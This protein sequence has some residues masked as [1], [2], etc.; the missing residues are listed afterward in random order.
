V[1]WL[2]L[3]ELFPLEHRG[4]GSA[5]ASSFSYLCAFVSVKTFV[6]LESWFGLHGAFWFY[7]AISIAGLWFVLCFVPETKGMSL[8]ELES[9]TREGMGAGGWEVT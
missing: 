1:S 5:I 3:A 4:L 6:D 2:L 8:T 9:K 7:S